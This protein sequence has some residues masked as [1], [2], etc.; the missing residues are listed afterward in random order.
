MYAVQHGKLKSVTKSSVCSSK[1]GGERRRWGYMK[2]SV[3]SCSLAVPFP[4]RFWRKTLEGKEAARAFT[5]EQGS[6]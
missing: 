2:V 4:K 5:T 1:Y 3:I 6:V